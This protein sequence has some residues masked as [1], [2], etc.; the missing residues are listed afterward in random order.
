MKKQT[1]LLLTA[2]LMIVLFG[3]VTALGENEQAS[4]ADTDG[5][6]LPVIETSDIH[7]YIVDT[8]G[9]NYE[10]R[11][12]YIAD[13]INDIRN[14]D[15]SFRTD[16][17]LLLDAGDLYQGN[18]LSN[19]LNGNP[20]SAYLKTAGYDA[21]TIGNHEFDWG[22]NNTVD[23]DAT[24]MD[25]SI[26][27][28][29]VVNDI[30]V[31]LSN[32]YKDG[33]KVSFTRDY[34]ILDKTAVDSAGNE[35]AVRVAVIG[36]AENYAG[37]IMYSKF[38]GE[39]YRI[40]E[41]YDAV[42]QLA[43]ELESS[44]QCDAT[45]VLCHDS[46]EAMAGHLGSGTSV[47]LVLGG[48]THENLCGTTSFGLTYL[49]PACYAQSYTSC[50]IVFQKDGN[51]K[52]AFEQIASERYVPVT[53]DRSKLYNNEENAEELDS[54]VI[55]ISEEA[56]EELTDVMNEKIGY[57]TVSALKPGWADDGGYLRESTCGNWMCSL[58]ARIGDAEIGIIN[59]GGIRTDL[60]V[61]E[62][63]DRRDIVVS[64]VYALFPFN[65][66]IYSYEITYEELLSVL[67]YGLSSGSQGPLTIVT[68]IDCYYTD[69]TVN[70]LVKD[71]KAIYANGEWDDSWKNR[72][73]KI[74][75]SDYV[76]T[77]SKG[78]A[79]HPNPMLA[80]N[81]T[82]KLVS[83]D[84][85]DSETAMEI[86]RE[87]ALEND[88]FLAID[89]ERHFIESEYDGTVDPAEGYADV[90]D[91][92]WYKE[93]VDYVT[94]KNL[95]NGTG[96]NCFSPESLLD[97]GMIVT[98]LYRLDM[99]EDPLSQSTSY[100]AGSP[101]GGAENLA[102]PAGGGVTVGDG[103]GFDDVEPGSW[104][105]DAVKWAAENNI[106]NGYE[107]GEFRPGQKVTRQEM[108]VMMHRYAVYK[109]YPSDGFADL[110][111]FSDADRIGSWAGESMSWAV[112]QGLITGKPGNLLDPQGNA[113]RAQAATILMRFCEN[114]D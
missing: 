44:G 62:G 18:I 58:Y 99:E 54:R 87:E 68:G 78:P 34:V 64:D 82:D 105:E 88:G 1:A 22:I 102:S 7:G 53:T 32:L 85:I 94:E 9:E 108:A 37:D 35:L 91:D 111:A 4:S 103:G 6:Q 60:P 41:D 66:C 65:N 97:R 76:A 73:V 84:R 110:S 61:E 104:Y 59:G 2:I 33:E 63:K 48:H 77:S 23:A 55:G 11:L 96:N 83:N 25:C 67:E 42:N 100:S 47:D 92:A 45:I 113:T 29:E 74:A 50:E 28:T 49:Q 17:T 26:G 79:D 81:K 93:A 5:W 14:R 69:R 8:T 38:T 80:W 10:Y 114:I 95:M 13:K 112:G 109:K 71:G 98:I 72:T 15:G 106:V 36:F 3:T 107:N 20:L 51:G 86:L 30:P 19:L 75:T 52:P 16:T 40:T 101:E 57:I 43:L 31:V 89:P 56:L 46:A 70:A 90:A 27:G 12:S 24:V 21:V 39:G